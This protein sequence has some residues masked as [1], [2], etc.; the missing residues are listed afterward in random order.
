M[1]VVIR[2]RLLDIM[3]G[4]ALGVEDLFVPNQRNVVIN[5]NLRPPGDDHVQIIVQPVTR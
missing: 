2:L 3:E 5:R 1:L 4:I